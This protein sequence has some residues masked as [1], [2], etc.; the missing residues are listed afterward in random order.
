MVDVYDAMAALGLAVLGAGLALVDVR[1]ALAVVGG[2][3]L[4]FGVLGAVLRTR[5]R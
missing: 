5:R 4:V 3:L 1:L 2:V